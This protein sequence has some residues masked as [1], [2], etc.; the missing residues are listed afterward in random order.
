MLMRQYKGRCREGLVEQSCGH[1]DD[2]IGFACPLRGASMVCGTGDEVGK[3]A[4]IVAGHCTGVSGRLSGRASQDAQIPC[5]RTH[6]YPALLIPR[7]R[8]RPEPT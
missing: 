6:L 1:H 4:S 3:A 7:T 5:T 8:T 2:G